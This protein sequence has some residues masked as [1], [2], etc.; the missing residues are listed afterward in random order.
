MKLSDLKINQKGIVKS[1]DIPNV[2]VKRH[3]MEMGLTKGVKVKVINIAPMGDPL[4]IELRGYE[5]AVRKSEA[6]YIL[7]E[8]V[9]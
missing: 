2:L 7:V 9:A 6:K 3:L 4:S 8:V 1:I 5:L